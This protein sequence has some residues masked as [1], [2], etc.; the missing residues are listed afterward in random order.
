MTNKSCSDVFAL[1]SDNTFSESTFEVEHVVQV[2][3]TALPQV[4]TCFSDCWHVSH[5]F[6]CFSNV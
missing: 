2:V 5:V 6:R 4:E 3:M 1:V